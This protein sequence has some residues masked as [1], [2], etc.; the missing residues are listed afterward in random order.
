M[1]GQ[2]AV[3]QDQG[4]SLALP[5]VSDRRAVARGE[6]VHAL[7]VGGP[8]RAILRLPLLVAPLPGGTPAWY[9]ILAPSWVTPPTMSNPA[10]PAVRCR[11]G[12][13]SWARSCVPAGPGWARPRWDW[14]TGGCGGCP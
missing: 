10:L 7:S 4:R 11:T 13:V 3:N 14:R 1:D 5:V 2:R 6:R 9:G 12:A 8:E